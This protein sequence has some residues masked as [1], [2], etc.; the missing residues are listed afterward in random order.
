[1]G[2]GWSLRQSRLCEPCPWGIRPQ[3]PVDSEPPLAGRGS[4]EGKGNNELVLLRADSGWGQ[5]YVIGEAD[6]GAL[7]V[8]GNGTV[9]NTGRDAR[10]WNVREGRCL[11][12]LCDR[13]PTYFFHPVPPCSLLPALWPTMAMLHLASGPLHM[14]MSALRFENFKY[15]ENY[16]P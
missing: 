16:R 2:P 11:R 5:R 8:L 10:I 14:H 9:F 3:K 15:A 12:R 7:S 6:S 13:D 1:M 4:L